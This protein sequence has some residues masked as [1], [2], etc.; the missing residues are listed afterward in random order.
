LMLLI[1]SY[2]G[3]RPLFGVLL[4]SAVQGAVVGTTLLLFQGRAGSAPPPGAPATEDGWQPEPTALPYGPWLALAALEIA[5]LGP[6]RA[7][8]PAA[9]AAGHRPALGPAM[10]ARV[11]AIA[12]LLAVLA[13]GITWLSFQ[14]VILRLVEALRIAAPA[15][16]ASRHVLETAQ[17][18]LP[19]YLGLDL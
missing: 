10:R 5:F 9:G 6:R 13:T 11:A 18:F 2:L 4:L 12:F 8:P 17:Q 7:V 1:G 19:L 15:G 3:W 16:T 14:P